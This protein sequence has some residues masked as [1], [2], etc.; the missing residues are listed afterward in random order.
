[1][2]RFLLSLALRLLPSKIFGV[3]TATIAA[4]A[5]EIVEAFSTV[6]RVIAALRA[7]GQDE[8]SAARAAFAT[9][10]QTSVDERIALLERILAEYQKRDADMAAAITEEMGAPATPA[11]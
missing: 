6:G 1:M 10:S 3:S 11:R 2:E 9:Y 7:N 8:Q 4:I 5:P